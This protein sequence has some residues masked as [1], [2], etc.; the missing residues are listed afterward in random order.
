MG[1]RAGRVVNH[2]RA[3]QLWGADGLA[4]TTF[5]CVAIRSK[6]ISTCHWSLTISNQAD[7]YSLAIDAIDRIPRF[8]LIGSAAREALLNE[9]IA[10]K[11]HATRFGVD[12][13]EVTNWKWP[14]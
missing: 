3:C 1:A 13:P 9:Q 4:G 5:T 2:M 12:Q 14:F 11:V 6:A 7:R 8:S 10:C